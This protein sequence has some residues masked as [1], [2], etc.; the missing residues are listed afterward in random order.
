MMNRGIRS[1][2][3][4]VMVG[5]M[6]SSSLG[7]FYRGKRVLVTG[8]TGFKGS[9]LCQMLVSFGAKVSGYALEPNT[10]PNLYSILGLDAQVAS[11]IGDIR[12]YDRF[13]SVLKA[14][15]PEIVFHLAAQP[16]VRESYDQP[17]YT[18]QTNVMGTA[19]V[20]EAMRRTPG[21]RAAVMI[22]TDKV[23]EN[24]ED[25]KAF[26]EGDAL[27]GHDPY[28]A[29]KAAD[30]IIISSYIRSFFNPAI[31]AK[32]D[33]PFVASARAGN[34]IGGGDWSAERLIPDIVAAKAAKR[35]LVLRNPKAIR[36]WQH[37]LD[38]LYGYLLLAKG[39]NE[40]QAPL[41]GAFNFS[42][43]TKTSLTVEQIAKKAGVKCRVQPNEGKH[44]AQMLRLDSGKARKLLGWKDVLGVDAGLTWTL[45]WY[46]QHAAGKGMKAFTQKQIE[47]YLKLV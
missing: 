7:S 45:D 5:P 28:S 37:V 6:A 14:E 23:Y 34:V 27:G 4:R 1:G 17:L 20:L 26:K 25:G 22:T 42:P 31:A 29:S 30:E 8:H 21:I 13:L 47:S 16:L 11:H 3:K 18:L 43:S 9:W 10:E 38:P 15:R 44:E 46:A 35:E 36:P 19:H 24:P 41:I 2:R 33:A 32:K 40:G 39:L 12:E